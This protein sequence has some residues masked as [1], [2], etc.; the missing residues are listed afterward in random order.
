M[1]ITAPLGVCHQSDCPAEITHEVVNTLLK[2]Y[3]GHITQVVAVCAERWS[4]K[5][6]FT[7]RVWA[8]LHLSQYAFQCL[9]FT[10]HLHL[11]S[12]YLFGSGPQTSSGVLF[13]SKE[14]LVFQG[15]LGDR[16]LSAFHVCIISFQPKTMPRFSRLA[17]MQTE[18]RNGSLTIL[19]PACPCTRLKAE[20]DR[21][22][23]KKEKKT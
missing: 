3:Y 7:A 4:Q 9:Q 12:T 20:R 18:R 11:L 17:H 19:A 10:I 23:K 1:G 6:R 2:P 13:Y 22:R 21:K 14:S 5:C 8:A 15:L 16:V